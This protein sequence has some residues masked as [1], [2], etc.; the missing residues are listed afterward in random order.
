MNPFSLGQ[1]PTVT[2]RCPHCDTALEFEP[3]TGG[4]VVFT[5]HDDAFCHLATR[6][7][8]RMLQQVLFANQ[9]AYERKFEHHKRRLNEML[10]KHGLPSLDE[11]AAKAEEIAT[12][13]SIWPGSTI[14]PGVDDLA[15]VDA[16][17]LGA[18]PDLLTGG[19]G[20]FPR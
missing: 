12:G 9:E 10:A 20:G 7:R 14:S 8:V 13:G 17:G 19:R 11:Q 4:R 2:K 18:P 1:D 16:L 5:A 3:I 15:R 6:E